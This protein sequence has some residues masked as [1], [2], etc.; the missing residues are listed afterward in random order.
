M[1]VNC[2][3]VIRTSVRQSSI[4]YLAVIRVIRH[5]SDSCQTVLRQFSDSCQTVV[6]Q[7]SNCAVYETES[8]I[9]LVLVKNPKPGF[10]PLWTEYFIFMISEHKRSLPS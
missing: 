4:S 6:R 9:G 7:S 8:L 2:Q 5:L 1:F 3:N 10:F